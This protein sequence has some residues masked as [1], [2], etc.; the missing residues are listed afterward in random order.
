[1]KT[2]A[3]I[4]AYPRLA[5]AAVTRALAG[6]PPPEPGTI[7]PDPALWRPRR[8]CFVSLKDPDLRGCIGTIHPACQDLGREIIANALAAA[9]RD[10]R[11]PPLRPEELPGVLFSVDVL[12]EPEP[13]SDWSELDPARWGV[14]VSRGGRRGLLLPDLPGVDDAARQVAIAARKAGLDDLKNLTLHRFSVE[15]HPETEED[16]G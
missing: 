1:M 12:S 10:P 15:R 8:A 6:Q 13:V 14:I 5:R 3:V 2:P 9:A 4:A 11:F 7:D 16:W